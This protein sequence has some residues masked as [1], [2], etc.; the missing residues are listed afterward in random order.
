[1]AVL[2]SRESEQDGTT[3]NKVCVIICAPHLD[4][5]HCALPA[6]NLTLCIRLAVLVVL[7][8]HY[9]VFRAHFVISICRSL[10]PVLLKIFISAL[11]L[12]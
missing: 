8:K 3:N 10:T 6:I 1:M 11:L 2:F 5:L 9:Y 12:V 7:A 4:G